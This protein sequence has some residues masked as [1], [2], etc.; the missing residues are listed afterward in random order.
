VCDVIASASG[1]E[2][3]AMIR[4]W[5]ESVAKAAQLVFADQMGRVELRLQYMKHGENGQECDAKADR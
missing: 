3:N 2:R 4:R 1:A 5:C